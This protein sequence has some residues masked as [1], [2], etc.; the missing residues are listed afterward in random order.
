MGCIPRDFGLT[1]RPMPG[2]RPGGRPT[3]LC[4]QESRQRSRP[5]KT[6]P[7]GFP[8][9]LEAQGRAELTSLRSVQTGGAKLVLE[10]SFARALGFCASRRYRRGDPKQPNT[11]AK[12]E[13]RLAPAV[14]YAPFSTAEQRKSL[15]PRAQHAS[16]TDS[17]QLFDRSVAKG[18]LCGA[19]SSEQRRAPEAKRRAVRSGGALCLLSGGPESRSPA[20]AK[21]RLGL[22][23]NAPS[24]SEAR[25]K[26]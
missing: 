14:R 12:P 23:A 24:A 15:R 8:A 20:G 1:P 18:V 17:A 22:A 13:S 10:A 21:S 11:T 7:A 26:P 5:C 6:A 4:G 25:P 9:M 16:R 19:S 2:V 3:F